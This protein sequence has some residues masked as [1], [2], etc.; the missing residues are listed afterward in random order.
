MLQARK[1]RFCRICAIVFPV[2]FYEWNTSINDSFQF[3]LVFS[4]NHFLEGSFTFQWRVCGEWGWYWHE[5]TLPPPT[6]PSPI[7]GNPE[8]SALWLMN[9]SYVRNA[10]WV[11]AQAI[12][13]LH[14][15]IYI[16]AAPWNTKIYKDAIVPSG[17]Q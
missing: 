16:Y 14:Y 9:P 2:L 7:M 6:M 4:R 12:T 10:H 8:C 1:S 3:C 11:L 17:Q 15:I 13:C 5:G